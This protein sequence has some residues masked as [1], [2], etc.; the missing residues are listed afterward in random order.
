VVIG[1]FGGLH[2]A[3]IE[4]G[5]VELIEG[6]VGRPILRS[7]SCPKTLLP[8]FGSIA[9]GSFCFRRVRDD[10]TFLWWLNSVVNKGHLA[11]S[12]YGVGD[13]SCIASLWAEVNKYDRVYPVLSLTMISCA[14]TAVARIVTV[15]A[16]CFV[17]NGEKLLFLQPDEA[18]EMMNFATSPGFPWKHMAQTKQA[19]V[20][21]PA[22]LATLWRRVEQIWEAEPSDGCFQ[23]VWYAFLKEELRPVEKLRC[24]P[25]KIRSIS[26]A[27][28][29]MCIVGNQLCGSYNKAFYTCAESALFGSCVGI[30]P[31]HGGWDRLWKR[32]FC[33]PLYNRQCAIS[34]D[35]SQWDRSFSPRLFELVLQVRKG[36]TSVCGSQILQGA[37]GH[38]D[39]LYMDVVNSLVA[40]PDR[41]RTFLV[42][43]PGG[44]K[45]GWVNTTTDNTIGHLIVLTSYLVS[46]GLQGDI[47][48]KVM[49]ALYG[50]DNLLA[51]TEDLACHF[52]SAKLEEWYAGW[53]FELHPSEV[54]RG[55][56]RAD[57]VF[58]GGKFGVCS[59]TKSRVYVPAEP[60]KAYDSMIHKYKSKN[61]AFERACALRCLHFYNTEVYDVCTEY[62]KFLLERGEVT[63]GLEACFL[64][65]ESILHIHTGFEGGDGPLKALPTNLSFLDTISEL[66]PWTV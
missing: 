14:T 9:G 6:T 32:F 64:G 46:V 60:Q 10:Q 15:Q 13:I 54:V 40:V 44:M 25:P 2:R 41:D 17:K 38:I 66:L 12:T 42:G 48:K 22:T 20:D 58:L 62:A 52:T 39:K 45:S 21:D 55:R 16:Q 3:D 63:D 49:F 24:D 19:L 33:S 1:N 18:L 4:P 43:M 37:F 57:I 7:A 28:V 31:F 27:P 47:G 5:L 35:V 30:S 8:C 59:E 61:S 36:V 34:L 51:F 65:R 56:A 50:D 26:G 29:D 53:G 11:N 23:H